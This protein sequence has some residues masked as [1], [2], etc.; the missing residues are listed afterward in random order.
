MNFLLSVHALLFIVALNSVEAHTRKYYCV[1][2]T[3]TSHNE[4]CSTLAVYLLYPRQYFTSNTEVH[5]TTGDYHLHI[6]L[7]V[8]NVTNLSITGDVNVTI[9]CHN[10]YILIANSTMVQIS[11]IKL[12]NCGFKHIGSMIIHN[13]VTFIMVNVIFQNSFGY[14]IIGN[15]IEGNS[16]FDNI[17]IFQDSLLSRHMFGL[18]QM[19]FQETAN[20]Y[21]NILISGCRFY[22]IERSVYNSAAINISFSQQSNSAAIQIANTTVENIISNGGPLVCISYSSNN[23]KSS[24]VSFLNSNFTNNKNKNYSTI[25]INVFSSNQMNTYH[26]SLQQGTELPLWSFF[27]LN[28]TLHNNTSEYKSILSVHGQPAKYGSNASFVL[29]INLTSFSQNNAKEFFITVKLSNYNLSLSSQ[30]VVSKCTFSSNTGFGLEFVDVKHLIFYGPN[31]FHINLAKHT[32]IMFH[33]TIP[34]FIDKNVFSRNTAEIVMQIYK[35]VILM[36]KTELNFII[37]MITLHYRL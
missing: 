6:I 13:V 36:P 21:S 14:A 17:I 30:F 19:S 18:I 5:F 35:Y 24:R 23:K 12:I 10:A 1:I 33:N 8:T 37:I 9:W 26:S 27:L 3:T 15:N 22:N 29:H 34:L 28:C 20:D 16:T 32:I 25:Q 11:N 31:I 2:P 4:S 7:T